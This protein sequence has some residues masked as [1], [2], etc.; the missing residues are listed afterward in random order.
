MNEWKKDPHFDRKGRIPTGI[1]RENFTQEKVFKPRSAGSQAASHAC[2]WRKRI[3]IRK[4]KLKNPV[5]AG[6]LACFRAARRPQQLGQTKQAGEA[7]R[8]AVRKSMGAAETQELLNCEYYG[9]DGNPVEDCEQ[10]SDIIWLKF[11]QDRF[12]CCV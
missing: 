7:V 6:C 10:R 1:A 12:A 3:W 9:C 8:D 4:S 11:E 2:N 5:S